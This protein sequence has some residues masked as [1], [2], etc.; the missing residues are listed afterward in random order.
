MRHP[1]NPASPSSGPQQGPLV[2][3][4]AGWSAAHRKTAVFGWL[5]LVIAA[6]AAGQ[7]LGTKNL[8]SYDPGQAGR[9]ERVL[10]QPSVRTPPSESVLIQTHAAGATFAGGPQL[11]Q[12]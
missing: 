12:T 8:Q 3:R 1:H 5:L 4:L 6:V 7:M 2:E 11:R 10:N 9:A